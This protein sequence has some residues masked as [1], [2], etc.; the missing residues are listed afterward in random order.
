MNSLLSLFLLLLA[1][2]FFPQNIVDKPVEPDKPYVAD[3]IE[4]TVEADAG[5]EADQAESAPD[6][7][8]FQVTANRYVAKKF[9]HN[10][11]HNLEDIRIVIGD[12]GSDTLERYISKYILKDQDSSV[13]QEANERATARGNLSGVEH[14]YHLETRIFKEFIEADMS[15]VTVQDLVTAGYLDLEVEQNTMS[16]LLGALQA[17]GYEV[18]PEE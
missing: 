8:A 3:V 9:E 14:E 10:G 11:P 6:V 4:T 15:Q 13:L 5:V 2:L 18:Y 7:N 17:A 12:A 1:F 16:G